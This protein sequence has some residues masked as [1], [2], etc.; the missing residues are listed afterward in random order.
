MLPSH[1]VHLS[2]TCIIIYFL[3]FS[4]YA[5]ILSVNG[6]TSTQWYTGKPL[7]IDCQEEKK[8]KKTQNLDL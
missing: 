1:L 6:D 7:S 3:R 2:C 8:N 5:I 4:I